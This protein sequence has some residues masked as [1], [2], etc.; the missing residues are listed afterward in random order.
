M[1]FPLTPVFWPGIFKMPVSVQAFVVSIAKAFGYGLVIAINCVTL[2][3]HE[4]LG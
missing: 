2:L 3:R 1:L 4:I